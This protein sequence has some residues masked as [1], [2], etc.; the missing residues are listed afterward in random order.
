MKYMLNI[1]DLDGTLVD[2]EQ[3]ICKAFN[4]TLLHFGK[5]PI[6]DSVCKKYIG[7][8]PFPEAIKNLGVDK[9]EKDIMETYRYYYFQYAEKYQKLFDGI[10][11]M[12]EELKGKILISLVTNKGRDGTKITLQAIGIEGFFDYIV[13]ENDVKSIKPHRE[14]YDKIIELYK[15]EGKSLVPEDILMIGDS[16]LDIDFA[17]N[18][19]IDSAFASWGFFEEK[20]L[21]QAPTYILKKP[22]DLIDIDGIREVIKLEISPELDLHTFLPEDIPSAV[23]EYLKLVKEKGYKTI[24]IIHGKGKGIQRNI[25]HS[26]LSRIKGASDYSV[27]SFY[28]APSYLGGKGATVVKLE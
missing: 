25:V 2:S 19:G 18:A 10:K 8:I 22:S 17:R 6:A 24:R 4:D 27:I 14:P 15:K 11:E 16:P 7:Y 20:E 26:L 23:L 21:H 1:F 5:Q 12:L 13:T 28:D 3:A 9:N